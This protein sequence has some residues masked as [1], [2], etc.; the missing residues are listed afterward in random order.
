MPVQL[1]RLYCFSV[2]KFDTYYRKNK[3][4]WMTKENLFD[5]SS[6]ALL[7][8]NIESIAAKL[9]KT[10]RITKS[11]KSYRFLKSKCFPKMI[12]I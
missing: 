4:A 9:D 6:K 3:P 8:R 12:D 2:G 11:L 7:N 10:D 1:K 5:K